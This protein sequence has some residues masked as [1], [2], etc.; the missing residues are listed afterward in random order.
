MSG[1]GLLGPSETMKTLLIMRHAKSSWGDSSL[2]DHERPLNER[3]ERDAP[4]MGKLLKRE[5]MVPQA[6]VASSAARAKATARAVA[7]ASG[8][9]SEIEYAAALYGAGPEEYRQVLGRLPGHVECALV[10]GHNPSSEELLAEL[11]G[12]DEH[13]PTAAIARVELELDEWADWD[14][15]TSARL[16]EMWRPKEIK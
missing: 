7:E 5:G 3:G 9:A 13:F 15:E 11:T 16:V 10:V 1:G 2:P 4:R 8:F 14:D 6:I 12:E